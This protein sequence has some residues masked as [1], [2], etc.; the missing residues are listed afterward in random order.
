MRSGADAPLDGAARPSDAADAIVAA[1]RADDPLPL[2]V[3]CAGPLTNVADA[4]LAAPD[5][6]SRFSLVWVGGSADGSE[7][8]NRDTD[9]AAYEAVFAHEDLAITSFPLEA[10]RRC[11]VTLAELRRDVGG[12]GRLGAWLWERFDT[13]PIPDFIE[14]G[15]M[16]VLGD[17]ATLIGTALSE[18]S[19]EF[20]MTSEAPLRRVCSGMDFR[21]LVADLLAKLRILSAQS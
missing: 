8:Y 14:I 12:A 2:I 13:L 4:L 19:S 20:V 9:P 15:E 16:W 5:I 10:Y 17:S 3:V 21:L 1:A 11:A 7:E 6:A 18:Q